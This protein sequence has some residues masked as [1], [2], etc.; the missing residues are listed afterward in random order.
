M[1][2]LQN[3]LHELREKRRRDQT[4]IILAECKCVPAAAAI[5]VLDLALVECVQLTAETESGVFGLRP[6]DRFN[7]LATL[8][9]QIL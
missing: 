1:S 3:A 9:R 2:N 4:E 8:V 6:S 7:A 5:K